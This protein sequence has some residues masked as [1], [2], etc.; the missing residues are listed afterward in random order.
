MAAP[1]H[2]GPTGGALAQARVPLYVNIAPQL[3]DL[4]VYRAKAESR[5]VSDITREALARYLTPQLYL[6]P[7]TPPAGAE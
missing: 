6:T 1:L 2:K 4:L 5:S 7:P 3:R